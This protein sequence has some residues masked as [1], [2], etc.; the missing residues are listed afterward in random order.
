MK[1]ILQTI[2]IIIVLVAVQFGCSGVNQAVDN[3]KRLQFKLGKVS[4]LKVSGVNLSNI[5]SISDLNVLQGAN[6]LAAFAGGG[7]PASFTVNLIAKNPTTPGGSKESSS[8]I[9]SCDWRLLIDDK[10]AVN[11]EISNITIPG[12]G[13]ETTIPIPVSFDL[14]K[15]IGDVGYEKVMNLIL[16]IGGKNGTSTR[17][18]LKIQPTIDTFLGGISYP[19]EI[20]VIDKE[21]R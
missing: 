6:L 4:N 11:G 20:D 5:K 3:A 14:F 16:G 13:Q 18:T 1:R 17:L 15:L 19:G 7:M 9:K 10:E 12:V 8:I 21:F 2:N